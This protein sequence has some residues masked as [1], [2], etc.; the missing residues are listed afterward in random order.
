MATDLEAL[1]ALLLRETHTWNRMRT[2]NLGYYR[3]EVTCSCGDTL[4]WGE[5]E[6]DPSYREVMGDH[7]LAAAITHTSEES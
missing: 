4:W 2:R 3:T 1:R 7:L 6:G 5:H